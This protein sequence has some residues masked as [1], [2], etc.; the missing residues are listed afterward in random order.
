MP[1]LIIIFHRSRI[2]AIEAT[3]IS[4]LPYMSSAEDEKNGKKKSSGS[5]ALRLKGGFVS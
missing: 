1:I 3:I 2:R 4:M 5:L